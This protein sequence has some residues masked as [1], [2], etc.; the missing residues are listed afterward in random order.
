MNIFL[1]SLLRTVAIISSVC[2]LQSCSQ[3]HH[4]TSNN[5]KAKSIVF[6][7]L[8]ADA[9]FMSVN[10]QGSYEGFDVDVAYEIGKIVRRD[11]KIV[12]LGMAELLIALDLQKIDALMCGFSITQERL[13][14]LN[15]VHY[16]GTGVKTFPL[17]F[18]NKDQSH[19]TNME[20]LRGKNI[21]IGV[22]PGTLQEQ[23]AQQ[24]DFIT[25]KVLN[26]YAD[27]V[28]ELQYG[29]ID[30]ALFDEAIE[31]Y[32][33]RF[34]QFNV[35]HVALGAFE[36]LGHGIALHKNNSILGDEIR[37]AVEILKNNGTI[38]RL[39]HQWNLVGGNHE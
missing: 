13:Q 22:L 17:V 38:A 1:Y 5:D 28:L 24:F 4:Q 29:K 32:V 37:S 3:T 20:Q 2:L 25:P 10:E 15:L 9:P 21:T 33:Q 34:S 12:D 18:W 39:E 11:I 36:S 26:T 6:G 14:R 16:Q 31:S 7:M 27:I 23:F 19:V 8:P 30:A 35:A